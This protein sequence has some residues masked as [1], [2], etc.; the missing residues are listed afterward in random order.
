MIRYCI[1][2]SLSNKYDLVTVVGYRDS[3]KNDCIG[4]LVSENSR[5][6]FEAV[7]KQEADISSKKKEYDYLVD[8]LNNKKLS[9]DDLQNIS[10]VTTAVQVHFHYLQ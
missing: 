10:E 2:K 6:I 5:L 9:L 4:K 3:L 7:Y 1:Y 8:L